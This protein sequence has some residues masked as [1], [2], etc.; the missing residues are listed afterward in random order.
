MTAPQLICPA[1]HPQTPLLQTELGPQ[2]LP[3]PP[4]L[5]TSFEV[6]LHTLLHTTWLFGHAA[7]TPETQFCPTAQALPQAPQFVASAERSAQPFGQVTRPA[8]HWQTLA[9]HVAPTLQALP[10]MPQ[11]TLLEVRSEQTPLQSDCPA[12]QPHTPLVQ[13]PPTA[14]ALPHIPQL[15]T[16]LDT[17]TQALPQMLWPMGQVQAPAMQVAEAGHAVPQAPQLV[18][19]T[20]LSMH[21]PAQRSGDGA[22]QPVHFPAAHMAPMPQPLPHT[23]QFAASVWRSTQALPQVTFGAMQPPP[24]DELA[25]MPPA[26]L[27][28]AMP[29]APLLAAMPPAPPWPA[30]PWPAPP[31]PEALAVALAVVESWT[32]LPPPHPVT[33]MSAIAALMQAPPNHFKLVVIDPPSTRKRRLTE[34][35]RLRGMYR[36]K[37]TNSTAGYA[38]GC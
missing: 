12:G 28:A 21:R 6:S 20:S 29:P 25:A 36:G 13:T 19:S 18:G 27:L 35:S 7:H 30:P 33:P 23:P 26:P 3:Q 24:L 31:E 34:L 38:S 32:S 22:L 2:L 1:A 9:L 5:L 37:R 10:H 4:Q 16:S 17:S 14:Q 15:P 8:L 11:S